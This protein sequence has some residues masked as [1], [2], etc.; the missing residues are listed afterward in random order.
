MGPDLFRTSKKEETSYQELACILQRTVLVMMNL[1][2]QT[3]SQKLCLFV[4]IVAVVVVVVS[5][6]MS[7]CD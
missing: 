4:V 3:E 1:I 7:N 5:W 2:V 6:S